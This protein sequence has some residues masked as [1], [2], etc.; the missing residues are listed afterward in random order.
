L[1]SHVTEFAAPTQIAEIA[2]SSIR[3]STKRMK[4]LTH[5]KRP[6]ELPVTNCGGK[7]NQEGGIEWREQ[8]LLWSAD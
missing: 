7:P 5:K 8:S 3:R 6:P 4:R 1:A 2:S